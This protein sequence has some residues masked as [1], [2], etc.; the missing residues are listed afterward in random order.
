MSVA[1]QKGQATGAS[2]LKITIRDPM[3]NLAD[4][5]SI[6][7][8]VFDFTSGVEVLIGE[9]N[10]PKISSEKRPSTSGLP[11]FPS[12]LILDIGK[13]LLDNMKF[14]ISNNCSFN[15]YNP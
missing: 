2:D 10:L 9:P 11:P 5:Y 12:A 3:G 14:S 6:S 4:P 15:L 8:S 1:F 7:Y 13:I